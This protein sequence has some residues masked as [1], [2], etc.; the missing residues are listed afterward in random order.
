VVFCR[1][2]VARATAERFLALTDLFKGQTAALVQ[3][4]KVFAAA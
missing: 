4:G 2:P 3:A 1:E